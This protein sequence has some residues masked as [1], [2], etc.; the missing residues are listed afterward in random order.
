MDRFKSYDWYRRK[1]RRMSG[2]TDEPASQGPWPAG[3]GGSR[4]HSGQSGMEPQAQRHQHIM[5]QIQVQGLSQAS[6]MQ[7]PKAKKSKLKCRPWPTESQASASAD[8]KVVSSSGFDGH[9]LSG[10]SE[11]SPLPGLRLF[12]VLLQPPVQRAVS[13]ASGHAWGSKDYDLTV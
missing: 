9:L 8:V 5:V 4:G 2:G 11:S 10:R 3:G 13:P 7:Y 6:G 1:L 12:P